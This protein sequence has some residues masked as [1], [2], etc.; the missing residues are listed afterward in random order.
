MTLPFAPIT[1]FALVGLLLAVPSLAVAQSAREKSQEAGGIFA[2]LCAKSLP[3]M[4][5]LEDKVRAISA[6]AFA[7]SGGVAQPGV[8]VQGGSITTGISFGAGTPKWK[9]SNGGY[10]CQTTIYNVNRTQAVADMI[11]AVSAVH[12]ASVQLTQ[13]TPTPKGALDAWTVS[14]AKPGM[15]LV[16]SRAPQ[17]GTRFRLAWKE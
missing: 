11:A 12:P 9:D 1:K 3:G 8:Y 7:N 2:E 10:F 4:T 13:I 14:G 15:T 5:G 6:K 17:N 16:A